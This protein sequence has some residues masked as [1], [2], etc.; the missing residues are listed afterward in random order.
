MNVAY[1]QQ[2]L[3]C[4]A[5]LSQAPARPRDLKAATPDAPKVLQRNVYGW[6]VPIERGLYDLSESSQAALV[7]C[8]VIDVS[9]C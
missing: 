4:A 2:T 1:G 5:A 6:F 3:A 8:P 7:R 9:S